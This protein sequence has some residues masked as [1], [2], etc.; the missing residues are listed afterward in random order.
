MLLN[1]LGAG[2]KK[3]DAA[4]IAK[5]DLRELEELLKAADTVH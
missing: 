3:E 1:M 2:I 4:K 5:I